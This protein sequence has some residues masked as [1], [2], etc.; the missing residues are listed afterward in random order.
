MST[1]LPGSVFNQVVDRYLRRQRSLG[2]AYVHEERVFDALR[3]FLEKT[4]STDL[5]QALFEA[6][7]ASQ[8]HLSV[9]TRRNR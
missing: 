6:W 4:S 8:S 2:R 3:L 5:D 7:C 9:N 1:T